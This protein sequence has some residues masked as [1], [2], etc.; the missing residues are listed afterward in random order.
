M[1]VYR[2]TG[3]ERIDQI[4]HRHYGERPGIVEA[5]TEYNTGLAQLCPIPPLGTLIELPDFPDPVKSDD[6]TVRLWD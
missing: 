3:A 1:I 6:T 2:A 4:V 5:V